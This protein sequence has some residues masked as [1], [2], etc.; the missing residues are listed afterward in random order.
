MNN[1]Y[2][3]MQ[4]RQT[5]QADMDLFQSPLSISCNPQLADAIYEIDY[6]QEEDA[7]SFYRTISSDS[8]MS[9][10]SDLGSGSATMSSFNHSCHGAARISPFHNGL[11]SGNARMN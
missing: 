9:V 4:G 1:N 6:R 3:E 2:H 8:S 7:S 10:F 11:G 5:D